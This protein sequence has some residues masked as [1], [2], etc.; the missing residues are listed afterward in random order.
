MYKSFKRGKE[1]EDLFQPFTLGIKETILNLSNCAKGLIVGAG[2]VS[3][4]KQPRPL[5]GSMVIVKRGDKNKKNIW[6]LF[7]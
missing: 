1:G 2:A 3:L 5:V 7:Q 4:Q 6:Q